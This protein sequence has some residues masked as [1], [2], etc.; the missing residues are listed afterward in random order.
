MLQLRNY[1]I[2]LINRVRNEFIKYKRVL[3]VL[4]CGAGKTVCFAYMA[5]EHVKKNGN[6]WFLVHRQE[7][8]EQAKQT[9]INLNI[10]TDNVYIGMISSAMKRSDTPSLIIFDEAHHSTAKTWQRV[11]DKFPNSF[12]VGLTATP[13]RMNG[14]PLG[15]VYQALCENVTT[16][17]LIKN[18]YL[19]PYEYYAPN[20]NI[21]LP[22]ITRGE[23]NNAETEYKSVI[24]GDIKKYINPDSK[25]IV[26][27]PNVAFSQQLASE[28]PN[29]AHFDGNTP[30]D[31]R[32]QIIHDF[33]TG[34]IKILCN[35][36]LIGEG[37]DVPDCDTVFLLRPT[38]STSLFIQ[39]SMRCMRYKPNKTA[40]IYD[41]VGNC[42]RH[43]LPGSITHWDLNQKITA[44]NPSGERD[45]ITRS[46]KNCYLVY[47]GN[48]PI[49]PYCHFDNGKTKKQIEMEKQAELE[50]ITEL[51]KKEAKKEQGMCRDL[52]SLIQL[53]IKRGYKNPY[54]WAKTIYN[55]R[56]NRR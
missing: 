48:N 32:K 14:E 21:M 29:A 15:N 52:Q 13:I 4:P 6:V 54:F 2:D 22:K 30:Y 36:D 34:K 42:H 16:D 31:E 9:F 23:F 40:R 39:Q 41:F 50:R 12:I 5:S 28:L 44:K 17:Y 55:S 49:C 3:A 51:Q 45:I 8:V 47:P 33:R 25:I 56:K 19:A 7:L 35:V 18:N 20:I 53:G 24:Y 10:P 38:M 11:I 26:Y 46:C 1:Q 37:F 27:C 43:G